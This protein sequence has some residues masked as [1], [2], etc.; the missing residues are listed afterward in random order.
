MRR[1]PVREKL[2]KSL[3]SLRFGLPISE[4]G[5]WVLTIELPG[6]QRN[7]CWCWR[8]RT[9]LWAGVPHMEIDEESPL[10]CALGLQGG[11]ACCRLCEQ[12]SQWGSRSLRTVWRSWRHQWNGLDNQAEQH[13][14]KGRRVGQSSW[15]RCFKGQTGWGKAAVPHS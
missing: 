7:R 11:E 10:P 6:T 15:T 9:Y 3:F 12:N 13:V 2:T 14:L 1:L 4:S 5:E 8:T